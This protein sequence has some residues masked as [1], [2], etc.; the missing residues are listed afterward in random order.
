M[1]GLCAFA[2]QKADGFACRGKLLSNSD[3]QPIFPYKKLLNNSMVLIRNEISID[4]F[5]EA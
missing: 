2:L 1:A 4:F 5:T 3:F